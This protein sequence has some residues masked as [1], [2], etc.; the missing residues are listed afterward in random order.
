MSAENP[1]PFE[2]NFTAERESYPLP[3]DQIVAEVAELTAYEA[4]HG[5]PFPLQAMLAAVKN[6]THGGVEYLINGKT[7]IPGSPESYLTADS[8]IDPHNYLPPLAKFESPIFLVDSRVG[9]SQDIIDRLPVNASKIALAESKGLL[10][11]EVPKQVREAFE[12]VFR[13]T[14]AQKVRDDRTIGL[15]NGRVVWN[16]TYLGEEFYLSQDY[17]LADKSYDG[18]PTL[19]AETFEPEMAGPEVMEELEDIPGFQL[20]SE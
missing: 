15:S 11:G 12:V 10:L 1:N 13:I 5:D 3:A 7:P 17:N 18:V 9:Y 8:P 6:V 19:G 14:G 4:D 20:G 16:G 2:L